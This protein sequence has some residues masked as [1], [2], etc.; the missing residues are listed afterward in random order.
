MKRSTS[1]TTVRTLN[2]PLASW[3]VLACVLLAACAMPAHRENAP[4]KRPTGEGSI[5]AIVVDPQRAPVRGATV[6]LTRKD[7]GTVFRTTT[8]QDGTFHMKVPAGDYSLQIAGD[9]VETPSALDVWVG[10]G[11]DFALGYLRTII[12]KDAPR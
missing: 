1:P 9:G 4:P 3:V 10:G 12:A 7:G 11:S 8:E 6:Q 2:A 5:S